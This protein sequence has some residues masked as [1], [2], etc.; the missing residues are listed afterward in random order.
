MRKNT[1]WLNPPM[2]LGEFQVH[3]NWLLRATSFEAYKS[4]CDKTHENNIFSISLPGYWGPPDPPTK[5]RC[6]RRPSRRK[7]TGYMNY[8]SLDVSLNNM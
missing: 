7:L 5:E 1:F 4:V 2:N 3:P 8:Q 6:Q